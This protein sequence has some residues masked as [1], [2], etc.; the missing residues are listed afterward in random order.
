MAEVNREEQKRTQVSLALD[1]VTNRFAYGSFGDAEARLFGFREEHDKSRNHRVV[2]ARAYDILLKAI[3]EEELPEPVVFE[4]VEDTPAEGELRYLDSDP[5]D[6]GNKQAQ[7][8]KVQDKPVTKTS[9]K[10]EPS[11][12]S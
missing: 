8:K 6:V 7:T 1:L 3:M 12:K 4:A 2:M 10:P 5:V 11:N 9:P